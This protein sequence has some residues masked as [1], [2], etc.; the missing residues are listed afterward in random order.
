MALTATATKSTHQAV[1]TVLKM[2]SPVLRS[3][4][5]E[6]FRPVI[7]SIFPNKPNIKYVVKS[8]ANSSL[9][10]TLPPLLKNFTKREREWIGLLF[11][12]APMISIPEFT[13]F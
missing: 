10:E 7:V 3:P 1:V 8:N 12:A 5:V 13:C 2:V 9:E 4:V 11:F 6:S